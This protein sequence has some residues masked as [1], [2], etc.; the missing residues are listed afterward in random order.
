M[1]QPHSK[2]PK[3]H[4][5]QWICL[6][7]TAVI[8]GTGLAMAT[9]AIAGEHLASTGTTDRLKERCAGAW[10]QSLFR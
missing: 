5:K 3:S 4:D 7:L 10:C 9:I 6:W 8:L 2:I 1:N